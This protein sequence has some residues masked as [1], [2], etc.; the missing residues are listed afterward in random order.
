[1]RQYVFKVT[2]T[3]SPNALAFLRYIQNLNFVI[4]VKID[5]YAAEEGEPMNIATFHK[6]IRTSEA[7]AAK[8]NVFTTRRVKE[9]IRKLRNGKK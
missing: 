3:S 5:N 4:P 2:D 7:E 6:R 1:M 8:G 9:E